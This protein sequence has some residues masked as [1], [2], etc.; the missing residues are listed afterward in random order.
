MQQ[1]RQLNWPGPL[2]RSDDSTLGTSVPSGNS[3]KDLLDNVPFKY[4]R[5]EHWYG[6]WDFETYTVYGLP[7]V[8]PVGTSFISGTCT[9]LLCAQ[10]RAISFGEH[11]LN[12]IF[13]I[14][15][16]GW[17]RACAHRSLGVQPLSVHP[18]ERFECS[19]CRCREWGEQQS[20]GCISRVFVSECTRTV[21][22]GAAGEER[23]R[24]RDGV[25]AAAT[26]IQVSHQKS[27]YSLL[28]WPKAQR[29]WTPVRKTLVSAPGFCSHGGGGGVCN[30][31]YFCAKN[32]GLK[33]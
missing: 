15:R 7:V 29:C 19:W 3:R 12:L 22:C 5:W 16:D 25:Y 10:L 18:R 17:F 13:K 8:P 32:C 9:Y 4:C 21:G 24:G 23:K 1:P 14:K 20:S 11:G 30:K 27:P 26:L 6:H 31:N 2:L 28:N 33:Y